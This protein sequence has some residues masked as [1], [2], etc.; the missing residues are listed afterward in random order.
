MSVP[1]DFDR[2]PKGVHEFIAIVPG[3]ASPSI[4]TR[5]RVISKRRV[6]RS[7]IGPPPCPIL[8]RSTFQQPIHFGANRFYSCDINVISTSLESLSVTSW[9]IN[10]LPNAEKR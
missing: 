5:A 2:R 10:Y 8:L 4:A 7:P 1:Y 6:E 9:R 3:R